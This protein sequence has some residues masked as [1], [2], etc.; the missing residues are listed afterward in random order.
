MTAADVAH[1]VKVDREHF[2]TKGANFMCRCSSSFSVECVR[3]IKSEL[4]M[5]PIERWARVTR[6]QTMYV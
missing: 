2:C 3:L 1:S 5:G 6:G 4:I